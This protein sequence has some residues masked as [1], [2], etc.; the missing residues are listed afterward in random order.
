[1]DKMVFLIL[2]AIG[3]LIFIIG[4]VWISV[5]AFKK[6]ILYG[7]MTLIIPLYTISYAIQKREK[8][9]KAFITGTIGFALIKAVLF[10]PVQIMKYEVK[11][12]VVEFFDAAE[13]GDMDIAYSYWN[14][15]ST[16]KEIESWVITH[17]YTVE[18]FKDFQKIE[19]SISYPREGGV[20]GRCNGIIIY[21]NGQKKDFFISLVKENKYWKFTRMRLGLVRYD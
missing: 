6:S 8:A 3:F 19:V 10:I 12:M 21:E 7:I 15:G 11:E 18:G 16:Q 5:I 17:K 20:Y 9:K 13:N 14:S 1:M 2:M 4:I